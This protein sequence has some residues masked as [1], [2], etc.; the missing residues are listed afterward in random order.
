[1]TNRIAAILARRQVL[2]H[3]V[4]RDVKVKYGSSVLGY[5]WSV[6]EPLML[7]AVYYFVFSF[8]A[9]FDIEDYPLFLIAA[10]L[11]WLWLNA[12]VHA[13]TKSLTGQAR[14]I[15]KIRLPREIFPLAVVG[16]KGFEFV[17]SLL[18]LGVFAVL[19]QRPPSRFLLA[20]PLAVALQV[21]L[22]TGVALLLASVNTVLRDVE[23]L[24]RIALRA[25]FY[26]SPV[27]YP[28]SLVAARLPEP[29]FLVYLLNPVVGIVELY[30]A[31]WFP[32]LFPGWGPVLGSAGVSVLALA[33]GWAVFVRLEPIVLKEL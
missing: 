29:V 9:R 15:T 27:V 11:P 5:F 18:V 19:A 33:V 6:L 14:L 16:A 2:G 26:L 1:M 7:T 24:V 32:D 22:L 8:I 17:A 31:V 25:M 21:V 23:R 30:R 3:L 12:T 13:A 4:G 10:M 28:L 20:L